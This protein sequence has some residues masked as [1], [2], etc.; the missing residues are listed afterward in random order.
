MTVY[1]YY[2]IELKIEVKV[3]EDNPNW[4]FCNSL[5]HKKWADKH[6][7]RKNENGKSKLTIRQMQEKLLQMGKDPQQKLL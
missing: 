4:P 6:Y 2:C 5:E 3:S 1:C 7:Y